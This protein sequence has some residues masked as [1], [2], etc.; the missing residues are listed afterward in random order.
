MPKNPERR[1]A[2]NAEL[3]YDEARASC[4]LLLAA[5]HDQPGRTRHQ[6]ARATGLS[7]STAHK[8]LTRLR[9]QHL[10]ERRSLDQKPPRRGRRPHAWYPAAA[11]GPARCAHR[12]RDTGEL[13]R[14]VLDYLRAHPDTYGHTVYRIA[15]AVTATTGHAASIGAVTNAVSS[16]CRTGRACLVTENPARYRA[17]DD[18]ND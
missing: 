4:G 8:T 5:V 7:P 9:D 3:D 14:Q 16:L 10:I 12:H 15:R 2:A 1:S 18:N 6:L 11:G 17:T 13:Q